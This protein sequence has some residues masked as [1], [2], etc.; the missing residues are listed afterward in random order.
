MAAA[1]LVAHMNM[2]ELDMVRELM[3][4]YADSLPF[5]LDFQGFDREL[6]ELPGD[7]APPRGA[8]LVARVDGRV[9]GCVALR[10]LDG[11]ACEMKRLFVSPAARGRG[12]GRL[13]AEGIIG[14]ARRLGYARIRLDTTP[15]MEAAQALYEQLGFKEIPPYRHNPVDGT[16]FLELEL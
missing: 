3:R 6:S 2:S 5:D 4:A 8:L 13:L 7:Y 10:H 1:P 9:G 15:G 14:E 12:I 16:R 11:D